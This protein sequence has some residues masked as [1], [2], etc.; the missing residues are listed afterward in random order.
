MQSIKL[1]TST[2]N[3]CM[4]PISVLI[5][6]VLSNAGTQLVELEANYTT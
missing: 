4:K 2:N 5:N 3:I 1:V 6:F